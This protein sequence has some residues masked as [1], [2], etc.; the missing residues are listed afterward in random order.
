MIELR[1]PA[2]GGA[3]A[4]VPMLLDT[5]ADVTLLPAERVRQLK[6]PIDHSQA[7]ELLAFDGTRSTAAAAHLDLIFLGL[8]FRGRFLLIDQPDG[9]LGRNILNHLKMVF[10]GPSLR[11]DKLDQ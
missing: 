7:Y 1:N 4:G 6:I 5:G 3:Q 10:D 2:T 11:W 9:V 8:T